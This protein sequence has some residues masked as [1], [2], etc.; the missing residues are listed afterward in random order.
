MR[1]LRKYKGFAN[2]SVQSQKQWN[3]AIK[4]CTLDVVKKKNYEK[5]RE[6]ANDRIAVAFLG[7]W[8][9]CKL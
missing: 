8:K 4:R 1:N 9:F 2:K 3:F 7:E 5:K 6:P